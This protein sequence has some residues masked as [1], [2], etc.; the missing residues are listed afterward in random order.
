VAEVRL[1][2]GFWARRLETNRR[3]TLPHIFH[4]NEETGRVANF[5]KAARRRTGAYQGR[6]FNDTDVYKAIEAASY[7][8]IHHPDS[9]LEQRLDALIELIAASQEPD[10]YLYP[11]R[12]V[13][14]RNPAPGAGP[15]RWV[16]LNGSH[17]L[18]NFGHLYEAAVAHYQATGKRA[19][20]DV[21]VKNADL[22]ARVFGPEGRQAAPGHE[23]IE[24]ALIRLYQATG[25]RKYVDLARFFL[26][27]RGK[28]HE[29][30]PYPDGPF[31]M[32]NDREYKQDHKP[33]IEQ[34]RAVGHAVRAMYLYAGMS[35][36]ASLTADTAYARALEALWRDVVSKRFY[37]T[38]GMGSRGGV[39][40]FGDDYELTNRTAYAETCASIGGVLWNHRE[41]L[42]TG[43][44]RYLDVLEQTLYNGF[45]SGVSLSGDSFFYQNP[46]EA[47][48]KTARSAY[49]EVACC[50]ANLAR[51]LAQIPGLVYAQREDTL[52]VNLFVASRARVKLEGSPVSLTQETRYPWEGR[53]TLR[54]EPERPTEFSLALRVPGWTGEGPLPGDLYRFLPVAA[55][56]VRLAVNGEPVVFPFDR[57]FA[58]LRRAWKAG[59]RVELALPMP[60]RRVRAHAGVAENA[61]K[62]ALQRGPLVYCAEGA[63]NGGRVLDLALPLEA[64]LGHEY[65][66]ELLE[67]LEVIRG[68]AG[69]GR[70]FVAIP[71]FAW[72]NRGP[73][74][75]AVWLVEGELARRSPP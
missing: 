25:N 71:Y 4:Q 16:H 5:E 57:G 35:D 2:D 66:P 17:E 63:D 67:G 58:R 70:E 46:L 3:V 20:L 62:L 50:P 36:V 1:E 59:D 43:E 49:F 32:Y 48:G 29:T 22:V 74:E 7:T 52:S 6:R 30:L 33:V 56:P 65:R 60:V 39:E 8:L 69:R 51:L 72:A 45:L 10:G 41:F 53:V 27:Q 38:G 21:A 68:K 44:G 75:M 28:S 54:V 15:D 14:P 73:G 34:E 23:E 18:Y 31:A 40:A 37:L 19:L 13:D 12:T 64:E 26:D 11:A 47:A 55:E 24:L 42:R 61:G 9:V